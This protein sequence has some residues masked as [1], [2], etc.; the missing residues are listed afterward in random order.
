MGWGVDLQHQPID[1]FEITHSNE[2]K[3]ERD[4]SFARVAPAVY[5]EDWELI[6]DQVIDATYAIEGE[7]GA[8][9]PV[10]IVACD[11]GGEDGVTDKAYDFYRLLK[12]KQKHRRFMLVK[13]GSSDA[14]M[15]HESY[16]DNTKRKDRKANVSGDVPLWILNS[17]KFKTIVYNTIRRDI[18]GPKYT[19]FPDWLPESFFDELTYEVRS[20][21]GKW[22]K[23]GKR[24][25]EAFDQF[26]Y[27]WGCIYKLNA[28]NINWERPPVYAYAIKDNPNIIRA[29]KPVEK[30]KRP[31]KSRYQF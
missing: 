11:S 4:G 27:S 24:P 9:M 7:Q 23:P 25:N 18:P 3:H 22:K 29:Q 19:I 21:D 20:P 31:R 14:D 1:R 6:I 12:V 5:L 28:H 30:T 17:N 10:H 15:L 16:P 26:Y 8:K 13:G 2:R